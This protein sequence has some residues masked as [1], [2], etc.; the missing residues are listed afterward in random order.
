MRGAFDKN[1]AHDCSTGNCRYRICQAVKC[2]EGGSRVQSQIKRRASHQG[3]EPGHRLGSWSAF[4]VDRVEEP[5][6]DLLLKRMTDLDG[7]PSKIPLRPRFRQT[8]TKPFQGVEALFVRQSTRPDPVD[9]ERSLAPTLGRPASSV[10]D[11]QRNP[12]TGDPGR[13]LRAEFQGHP[14]SD[15]QKIQRRGNSADIG[16]L[17]HGVLESLDV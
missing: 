8:E 1:L 10:P 3:R 6:Q 7:M 11:S 5:W 15:W 2:A 14:C 13:H 12:G 9:A 16:R 4:R 17:G